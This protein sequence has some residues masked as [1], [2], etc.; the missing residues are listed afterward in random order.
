MNDE[1]GR[2]NQKQNRTRSSTQSRRFLPGKTQVQPLPGAHTKDDGGRMN[3]EWERS[4]S[5]FTIHPLVSGCVA[6][7]QSAGL[8]S[9]KLM[10][11]VHP[12]PNLIRAC[13][14]IGRAR[15]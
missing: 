6:Q 14:S 10:V 15:V 11:R 2:M 13:S 4:D 3:D 9:P 8:I 5:S 7:R 1:G 12:S